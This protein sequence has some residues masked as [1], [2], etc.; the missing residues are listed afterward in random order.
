[1]RTGDG[2]AFRARSVDFSIEWFIFIVG[3]SGLGI[4]GVVAMAENT[5]AAIA[6][7]AMYLWVVPVPRLWLPV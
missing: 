5:G 4:T 2:R 7:A 3:L 6:V 1:M